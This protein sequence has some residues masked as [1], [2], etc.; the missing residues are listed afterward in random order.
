MQ[1]VTS[2]RILLITILIGV[3]VVQIQII[4]S[5][6]GFGFFDLVPGINIQSNAMILLRPGAGGPIRQYRITKQMIMVPD[7]LPISFAKFATDWTFVDSKKHPWI[8]N[9][10]LLHGQNI[11]IEVKTTA[12]GSGSA[13]IEITKIGTYGDPETLLTK[14]NIGVTGISL[15]GFTLRGILHRTHGEASRTCA[16]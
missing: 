8:C 5:A 13:D 10:S 2:S 14:M 9:D 3:F 16:L 11:Q 15:E 4:A 7:N 1:G 12:F 6:I